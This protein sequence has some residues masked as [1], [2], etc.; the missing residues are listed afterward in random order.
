MHLWVMGQLRHP[1]QRTL[2]LKVSSIATGYMACVDRCVQEQNMYRNI[3][4]MY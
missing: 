2:A 3:R 4:C 1:K